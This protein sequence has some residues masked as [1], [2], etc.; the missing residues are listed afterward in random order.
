MKITKILRAV[1]LTAALVLSAHAVMAAG[2][3]QLVTLNSEN[4][5]TTS[6]GQVFGAASSAATTPLLLLSTT[7]QTTYGWVVSIDFDSCVGAS[8]TAQV[9][10]YDATS[11][12]TC[13]SATE[14]DS[15]TLLTPTASTGALRTPLSLGNGRIPLDWYI[16]G[17]LY[18]A[19][20]SPNPDTVTAT[21]II[22]RIKDAVLN[23]R[24]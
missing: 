8:A 20:S 1:A 5:N 2:F 14:I 3:P 19:V 7:N 4:G 21:I 11:T 10:F 18:A 24:P 12:A 23:V 6:G 15:F 13:T 16:H 9:V 17:N 22:G